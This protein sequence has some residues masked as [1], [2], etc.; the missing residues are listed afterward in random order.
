MK[1]IQH[2]VVVGLALFAIYF[3]AGNLIFPPTIG[4]LSGDNWILGLT[5]FTI[6]GIVLPLLAVVAILNVGG[7]FEDLTA[8]ISPWFH[9]LFN[10]LLMVGIG[11][12][13]TIPRMS[14]TTHELGVSKLIPGTPAIVTIIIFFAVSY[15]FAMDQSNVIDKLGKY[16]TPVLVIVLLF[17]VIK[18][19]I[20]PVGNP[21]AARI[22]GVFSNAFLSAY[23][24]GDVVTG[25]F[26][27]P[28]FLAAITAYG[29]KGRAAKKVAFSGV[30]IAGIGLFV[31][32]GGLL[33]L[34]ASG[35][36]SFAQD[37][38]DTAL[39]SELIER[40]LG[41]AG[42][43]LLAVAIALAC[44]TSAIGVIVVIA[45]F[46]TDL[47]HN[48]IGYKVWAAVVCIVGILIGSL[49]VTSIVTYAMPIFTALYPVAIVLVLLGTFAKWIPNGG[50]YRGAILFTAVVSVFETI[51]NLGLKVPF[52][53]DGIQQL[54]L[55]ADGFSWV[56]P[57]IVGFIVGTF[58]FKSKTSKATSDKTIQI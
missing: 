11:M 1:T 55:A 12:L 9:K 6:T 31:I 2:T 35:S 19:L 3:G 34:G 54:P 38:G 26:C 18:G 15:F 7:R 37:I 14:A 51:G 53:F 22:D 45:Q 25:I 8:P 47:T 30:A 41:N 39:V 58:L 40:I 48:K 13:V 28:I 24:T 49:G 29:Y 46:L 50:S 17:I 52:L 32:Y 10:L 43:A 56:I 33:Y 5:S 27:A 21:I 42:S 57:A 4:N 36:G 23:Q 20:T 16:L 44:L